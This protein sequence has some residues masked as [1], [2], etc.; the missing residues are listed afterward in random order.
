M[1]IPLAVIFAGV[2]MGMS[3][4]CQR[5]T[6]GAAPL[7]RAFLNMPSTAAGEI[8]KLLSQTGTFG[9]VAD[10]APAPALLPYELNA[11]FWSDGAAKRR[12]ISVPEGKTIVFA[13]TGEWKF[14]PGT[15]LVKHFELHGRRLETRVLVLDTSGGVYG[16]SYKWRADQSDAEL[17]SAGITQEIAAGSPAQKWHFP[18]RADCLV[19]HTA[20]AGGVLGVTAR[21]MNKD[22]RF[23]DGRSSTLAVSRTSTGP[24]RPVEI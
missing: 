9:N 22:V 10:L 6:G 2:S 14:P 3:A 23:S 17:V 15:V 4:G 18:G 7:G 16:A 12:W 24:P 1:R 13:A 5:N 21:Q 8:P 20:N 11:P 19:C